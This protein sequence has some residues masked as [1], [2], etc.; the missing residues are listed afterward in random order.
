MSYSNRKTVGSPL[1]VTA[2]PLDPA[3]L[4]PGNTGLR[5]EQ[6]VMREK[7]YELQD[8]LDNG[9][10]FV[11]RPSDGPTVET[12]DDGPQVEEIDDG[13]PVEEIDHG[14]PVEEIDHGPPMEEINHGPPV[15]EIDH[16]PPEE[17]IDHGPPV[18]IVDQRTDDKIHAQDGSENTKKTVSNGDTEVKA[19]EENPTIEAPKRSK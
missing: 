8:K 13:P 9:L 19:S 12:I 15:E 10:P 5:T 4:E 7:D 3:I 6:P 18:E 11:R 16:G 14:P 1:I 17:E 2:S